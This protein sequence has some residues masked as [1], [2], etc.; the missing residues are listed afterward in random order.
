MPENKTIITNGLA[1]VVRTE[2]C[3]GEDF[4][5]DTATESTR[6]CSRCGHTEDRAVHKFDYE[7]Q[8]PTRLTLITEDGQQHPLTAAQAYGY[9]SGDLGTKDHTAAY[10]IANAMGLQGPASVRA[11]NEQGKVIE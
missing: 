8:G 4:H 1:E 3:A 9:M 5:W 7:Y 6:V 10:W 2:T 11:V